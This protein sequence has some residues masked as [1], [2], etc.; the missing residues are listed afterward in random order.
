MKNIIHGPFLYLKEGLLRKSRDSFF[1]YGQ[2][3]RVPIFFKGM[4]VSRISIMFEKD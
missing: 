1:N 3:A 2:K 4:I